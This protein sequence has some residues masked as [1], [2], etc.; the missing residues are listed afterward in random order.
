MENIRYTAQSIQ[1]YVTEHEEELFA[2]WLV[3]RPEGWKCDEQ[4][5]NTICL[6]HWL[7]KELSR[8]VAL[9]F[10]GA[11]GITLTDDDRKIQLNTFN[12]WSRSRTDLFELVAEIMNDVLDGKIL[13]DRIPHHRWG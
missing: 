13:R 11:D 5:K 7:A 9:E 1:D 8:L 2:F 6:N 3:G 4:T 10:V 12:R